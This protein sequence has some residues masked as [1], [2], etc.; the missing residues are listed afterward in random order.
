MN[1]DP[2]KIFLSYSNND[3]WLK[4]E[5]KSH[6]SK[7]LLDERAVTWH[8][9]EIIPGENLEDTIDSNLQTSDIMILMISSD[10]LASNYCYNLEFA[11]AN[12]MLAEGAMHIV[13][14]IARECD[15]KTEALKSLNATPEDGIPVNPDGG[16]R[17]FPELRDKQW[18]A[19]SQSLSKVFDRLDKKKEPIKF[20]PEYV[21]KRID[22]LQFDH[23]KIERADIDDLFHQ[24]E[25]VFT[26]SDRSLKGSG[27]VKTVSFL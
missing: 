13:P 14:V 10:F 26:D 3:E 7:H 6:L 1:I 20:N 27:C 18:T 16:T 8:Y 4:D 21:T 25:M 15:W 5:L 17:D 19:V 12:K 11:E 9:R 24:P 23:A 2:Y 22:T